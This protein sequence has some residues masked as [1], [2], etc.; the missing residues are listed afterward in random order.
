MR[1]LLTAV[2]VCALLPA[3]ALAAT[4]KVHGTFKGTDSQGKPVVI[5]IASDELTHSTVGWTAPC[6]QQGVALTGTTTLVGV[7]H[8]LSY[9]VHDTYST[10]VTGGYRAKHTATARFTVKGHR[11]KGTFRLVATVYKS[12]GVVQTTCATPKITFRAHK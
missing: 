10:A 1:R 7:L 2:S 12:Q 5:K 4:T 11:L 8:G 6:A 9:H 3:A